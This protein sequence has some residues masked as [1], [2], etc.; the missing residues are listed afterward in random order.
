M[1]HFPSFPTPCGHSPSYQPRATSLPYENPCSYLPKG[2]SHVPPRLT[3]CHTYYRT[4]CLDAGHSHPHS[5]CWHLPLPVSLSSY[6][7]PRSLGHRL[8]LYSLGPLQVQAKPRAHHLC[9]NNPPGASVINQ[10][11][12]SG[13]RLLTGF[14]TD[15]SIYL[16]AQCGISDHNTHKYTH[17]YQ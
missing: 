6:L 15:S 2:Q 8:Q 5:H 13:N 9:F 1:P 7:H 4:I 3:P 16:G 14:S 11:S 17:R 10:G 12:D